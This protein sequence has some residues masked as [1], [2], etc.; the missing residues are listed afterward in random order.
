MCSPSCLCVNESMFCIFSNF[1]PNLEHCIMGDFFLDISLVFTTFG[2]LW[3][4]LE[5]WGK[6]KTL[7][8]LVYHDISSVLVKSLEFSSVFLICIKLWNIKK[9]WDFILSDFSP[10][11]LS[12]PYYFSKVLSFLKISCLWSRENWGKLKFS[13]L[14][15]WIKFSTEEIL[16]F[17]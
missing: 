14:R 6:L 12:F 4:T 9:S 2:W 16:G 8:Y 13:C 1:A 10:V 17:L 15:I 5:N 11:F 7:F 3:Q